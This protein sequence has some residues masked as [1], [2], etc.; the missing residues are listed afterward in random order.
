MEDTQAKAR[1]LPP[2][3]EVVEKGTPTFLDNIRT[4]SDPLCHIVQVSLVCKETLTIP[5]K[6]CSPT[7]KYTLSLWV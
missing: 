6:A 3:R 2:G 4:G 7:S 5:L 1:C